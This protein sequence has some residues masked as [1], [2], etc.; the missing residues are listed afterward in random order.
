MSASKKT[1]LALLIIGL[2]F[3]SFLLGIGIT[4]WLA[5]AFIAAYGLISLSIIAAPTTGGGI[6]LVLTFLGGIGL[7]W[8]LFGWHAS[9]A[10]LL[11][12]CLFSWSLFTRNSNKSDNKPARRSTGLRTSLPEEVDY[13][14]S[15][16][17]NTL[18]NDEKLTEG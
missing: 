15:Y 3:C 16:P 18:A 6:M 13:I 14:Q 12:F 17:N 9:L 11:L 8:W 7:F 2:A 10:Y 1:G 5:L 4:L